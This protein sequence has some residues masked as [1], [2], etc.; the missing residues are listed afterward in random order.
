MEAYSN[1]LI[2]QL[3][4]EILNCFN[5]FLALFEETLLQRITKT[6]FEDKFNTF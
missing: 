3:L 6:I 2:S 1:V 5:P 4:D